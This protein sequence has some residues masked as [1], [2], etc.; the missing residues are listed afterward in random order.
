MNLMGLRHLEELVANRHLVRIALKAD[1]AQGQSPF[2]FG[3]IWF[4]D[5]VGYENDV[6]ALVNFT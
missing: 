3:M 5:L 1:W 2:S 6:I 4:D